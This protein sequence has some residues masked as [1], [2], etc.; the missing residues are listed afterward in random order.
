MRCDIAP[1]GPTSSVIMPVTDLLA[2]SRPCVLTA[3]VFKRPFPR[4]V[5]AKDL[6]RRNYSLLRPIVIRPAGRK[7][8]LP[9]GWAMRKS[10]NITMTAAGD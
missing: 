3:Y 4:T 6:E 1:D 10:T 2:R 7:A 9:D 8:S 5:A